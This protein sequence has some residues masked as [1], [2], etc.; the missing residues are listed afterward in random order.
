MMIKNK[1]GEVPF[2]Q[3]KPLLFGF[4]SS[5]GDTQVA[6]ALPTNQGR[7]TSKQTIPLLC[8]QL[9]GPAVVA[10]LSVSSKRSANCS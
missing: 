3:S 1:L 9:G 6:K 4:L 8:D 10:F 5:E 2:F 7:I